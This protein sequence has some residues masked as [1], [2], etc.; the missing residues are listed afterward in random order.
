MVR[1]SGSNDRKGGR[2]R[3]MKRETNREERITLA[4][5]KNIIIYTVNIIVIHTHL[6]FSLNFI[7][8]HVFY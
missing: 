2:E 4:T 8:T 7:N 6:S 1:K 3:Q 5:L